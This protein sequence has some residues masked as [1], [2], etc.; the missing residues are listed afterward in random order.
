MSRPISYS[1][2]IGSN[3]G[4]CQNSTKS[5]RIPG[6]RSSRIQCNQK[7]AHQMCS[8]RHDIYQWNSNGFC[9]IIGSYRFVIGLIHLGCYEIKLS[10][11]FDNE[12]RINRLSWKQY[13]GY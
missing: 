13:S 4:F 12:L 9:R 2:P 7:N 6:D 10:N 3:T 1:D 11:A 5:Y 8:I